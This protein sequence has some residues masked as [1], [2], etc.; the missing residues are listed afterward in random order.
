[1]ETYLGSQPNV[2]HLIPNFSELESYTAWTQDRLP[3]GASNAARMS[4]GG[5]HAFEHQ[6]ALAAA[7]P[8]STHRTALILGSI[9]IAA[10]LLT[11]GAVSFGQAA[12]RGHHRG[13]WAHADLRQ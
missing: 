8:H 12:Q 13:N 9:A 5:F 7:F 3:A 2:S 6:W 1:M 4:P 11:C 10:W